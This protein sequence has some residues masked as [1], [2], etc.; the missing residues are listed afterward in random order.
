MRAPFCNDKCSTKTGKV[1]SDYCA[2]CYK[3]LRIKE[4]ITFLDTVYQKNPSQTLCIISQNKAYKDD[5]AT[6]RIFPDLFFLTYH[7]SDKIPQLLRKRREKWHRER[8]RILGTL[9]KAGLIKTS[10]FYEFCKERRSG[11]P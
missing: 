1:N 9:W 7:C 5:C 2:P 3:D 8:Y 11:S 4:L 10:A 6:K